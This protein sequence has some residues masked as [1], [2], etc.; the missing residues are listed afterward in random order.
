MKK[1]VRNI[2]FKIFTLKIKFPGTLFTIF[3]ISASKYVGIVSFKLI[4]SKSF[5]KVHPKISLNQTRV[6]KF[7]G[8]LLSDLAQVWQRPHRLVWKFWF[9]SDLAL[10]S[11]KWLKSLYVVNE[12]FFYKFQKIHRLVTSF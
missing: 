4:G 3:V 6:E 2:I 12:N 8:S 7:H 10:V 9:G 1:L 5:L 11:T